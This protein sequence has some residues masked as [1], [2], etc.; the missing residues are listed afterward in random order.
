VGWQPET[1]PK[2]K[3]PA[4]KTKGAETMKGNNIELIYKYSFDSEGFVYM[5]KQSG[6]LVRCGECEYNMPSD[7]GKRCPIRI[8]TDAHD[9]CSFA[10][11][12]EKANE[13]D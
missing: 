2:G 1:Q 3:P 11:K 9:Y 10:V 5:T 4:E 13:T 8:K 12:K 7:R 6:R